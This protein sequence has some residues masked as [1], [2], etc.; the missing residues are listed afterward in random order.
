MFPIPAQ[1]PSATELWQTPTRTSTALISR[2]H[3]RTLPGDPRGPRV[4]E[5]FGLRPVHGY[6]DRRRAGV[7]CEEHTTA[8]VD[9]ACSARRVQ[10]F[11]GDVDMA[12]GAINVS[13]A[14]HS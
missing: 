10:V 9:N 1:L 13:N 7:T 3:G 2:H 8:A 4:T 5:W 12:S 11:A 14:S 6:S